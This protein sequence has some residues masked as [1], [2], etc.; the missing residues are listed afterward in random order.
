M[1]GPADPEPAVEV[2][3]GRIVGIDGRREPEFDAIDHFLALRTSPSRQ[4]RL[5]TSS[6]RD[7]S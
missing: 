6:S 5:T 7:A 4:Q 1:N 2:E 3:G